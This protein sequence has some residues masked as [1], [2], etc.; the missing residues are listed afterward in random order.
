LV[1]L[2]EVVSSTASEAAAFVMTAISEIVEATKG[3]LESYV[4][5]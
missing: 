3:D 5:P 1:K 4:R 2:S